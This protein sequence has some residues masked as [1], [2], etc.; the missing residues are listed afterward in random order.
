MVHRKIK[1]APQVDEKSEFVL[2]QTL[3]RLLRLVYFVKCWHMFWVLNSKGLDQSSGKEESCCL[4][5]PSSTKR[6]FRHFTLQS[7][8]DGKEMYKKASCTCKVVVLLI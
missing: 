5:F 8:S 7:C 3:W 2:L 4:V 1:I 6:E